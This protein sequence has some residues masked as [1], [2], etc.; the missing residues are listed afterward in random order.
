MNGKPILSVYLFENLLFNAQILIKL[1]PE[2]YTYMIDKVIKVYFES[3]NP[4]FELNILKAR[5]SIFN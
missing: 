1:K 3:D 5:E 4:F 2:I